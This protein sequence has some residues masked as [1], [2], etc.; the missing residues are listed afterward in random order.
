MNIELEKQEL[1]TILI[2][3]IDIVKYKYDDT[4]IMKKFIKQLLQ[5][6]LNIN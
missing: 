2:E 3:M 6:R 1:D 5:Y 4:H